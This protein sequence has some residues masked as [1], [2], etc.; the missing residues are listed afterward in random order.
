MP[1]QQGGGVR[2]RQVGKIR[3]LGEDFAGGGGGEQ[4]SP[5]PL[6]PQAWFLGQP[7]SAPTPQAWQLEPT[8]V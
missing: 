6:P 2:R 5:Q 4:C 7:Q 8:S 3:S 1:L